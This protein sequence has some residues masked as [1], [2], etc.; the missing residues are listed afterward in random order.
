[1]RVLSLL[2]VTLLGLSGCEFLGPCEANVRF[3][4]SITLTD[5]ITGGPVIADEITAIATS[6]HYADTLQFS[7]VRP[8]PLTQLVIVEDRAGTYSLVVAASQFK[9]WSRDGIR[10][11]SGRCHVNP[12]TLAVRLQR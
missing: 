2:A 9:T 12:V 1:M 7:N 5:S 11:S 8:D 6:S 10:V 4:I 3:G